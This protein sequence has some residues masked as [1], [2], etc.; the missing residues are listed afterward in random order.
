VDA[1]STL[2]YDLQSTK[3]GEVDMRFGIAALCAMVFST[4]ANASSSETRPC[5][6]R[7]NGDWRVIPNLSL[8]QCAA[9]LARTP[10]IYDQNGFKFGY[11]SGVYLA[12]DASEVLMSRDNRRWE[13]VLRR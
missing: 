6:V 4:L 3:A 10:D 12:A 7:L 5:T 9:E 13:T 8:Q 11:W 1:A 2:R